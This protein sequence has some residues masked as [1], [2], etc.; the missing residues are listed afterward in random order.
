MDDPIIILN[1]LM[2]NIMCN[3]LDPFAA[4]ILDRQEFQNIFLKE[5]LNNTNKVTEFVTKA[6][7]Y[8]TYKYK[9]TFTSLNLDSNEL[10]EITLDYIKTAMDITQITTAEILYATLIDTLST[11]MTHI[12][13]PYLQILLTPNIVSYSD[14]TQLVTLLLQ[15]IN[16][17][18]EY[19]TRADRKRPRD[20]DSDSDR[21]ETSST[22][23]RNKRPRH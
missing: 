14:Y 19:K 17:I 22:E 12:L 23:R 10:T 5:E 4:E 6:A 1:N 2:R 7:F 9:S 3:T 13:R 11:K 21:D 16:N 15:K 18:L 20:T 8:Y